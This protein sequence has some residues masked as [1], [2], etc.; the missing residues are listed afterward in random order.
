MD[1]N[2]II[3]IVILGVALLG[4][5]SGLIIAFVRGDMKKFI[6]EKM[7]EAEKSGKIGKEKLNYVL[8]EFKKKYK[9][10]ELI[11]NAKEFIEKVI[12]ITKQIN[13]K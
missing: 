13:S 9:I 11:F 6:E 2:A 1:I 7:V 5:I 12:A 4:S 8:N 10:A 3:T